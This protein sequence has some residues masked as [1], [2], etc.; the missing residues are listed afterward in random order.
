M[1]LDLLKSFVK[2]SYKSWCVWL[3]V[4]ILFALVH[5]TGVGYFIFF[6]MGVLRDGYHFKE[7]IAKINKLKTRG[8][9]EEDINNIEFSKA[10]GSIA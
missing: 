5:L 8:L 6:L 7:R 9:T 2:Y 10:S 1:K 4:G 3:V